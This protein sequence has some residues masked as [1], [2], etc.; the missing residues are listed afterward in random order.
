MYKATT[1]ARQLCVERKGPVLL[2]ALTYREGNHS[3]SDDA[4]RYC[5]KKVLHAAC[6]ALGN[7]LGRFESFLKK[8]GLHP[9]G[10]RELIHLQ[11]SKKLEQLLRKHES[12]PPPPPT[13]LLDDVYDQMPE[14]LVR[15]QKELEA[16]LQLN[17]HP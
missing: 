1:E 15:Q 14:R 11:T 8:N 2:E 13:H 16:S 5:D 17:P 4:T 6:A 9:K 10:S 7:S 3:S 12:L